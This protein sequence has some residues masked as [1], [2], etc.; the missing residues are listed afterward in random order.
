[1]NDITLQQI[2]IFLTVAEQLSL[3]EAAKDL[4]LNQSAVSRWIQRLETSLNT[5]LFNRNYRGVELT[6]H[7]EFLYRE[8][9]PMYEKLGQTLQN[10]RS[11]YD[12]KDN[13]LRVGCVDSSEVIGALKWAVKDFEAEYPDIILKIEL[14]EFADIREELLCGNLD[15]IVTY[16]LGMGQYW[17][18]ATRKFKKLD[19]YIAV[20]A[21]SILAES[22]SIP[23]EALRN[24]ALYLLYIAEMKEPEIRALDTCRKVGFVPREIRYVPSLFALELALKNARGFSIGGVNLC[25]HFGADIRLYH[26]REPVQDQY[27]MLAWRE[28]GCSALT[29]AFVDSIREIKT[30]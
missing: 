10:L 11:M 19:T 27:V 1:V 8:L 26:V 23:V 28:N 22:A 12:F 6:D 15:C 3:S 7:G 25:D 5:K 9:K 17:N 13:I 2:E 16:S 21:R 30:G 29:H 20:S 14:F 4:F 18:V 24:E